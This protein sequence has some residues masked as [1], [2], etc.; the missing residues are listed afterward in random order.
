MQLWVKFMHYLQCVLYF[1][2]PN[3]IFKPKEMPDLCR[4]FGNAEF[5]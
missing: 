2:I 3:S 4:A 1:Y 5:Y